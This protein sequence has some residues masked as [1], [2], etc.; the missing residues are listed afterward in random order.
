MSTVFKSSIVLALFAISI[1]LFWSLSE[2][3]IFAPPQPETPIAPLAAAA[4]PDVDEELDFRIAQRIGSLEIWRAFLNAHASGPHA[5]LA[6]AEVEKLLDAKN[7]RA[8]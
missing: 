6:R 5:Q 4:R 3:V 1:Y 7:T 2:D 8:E